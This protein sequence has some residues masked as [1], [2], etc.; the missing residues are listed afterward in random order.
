MERPD[1]VTAENAYN[2]SRGILGFTMTQTKQGIRFSSE[3]TP[4][5]SSFIDTGRTIRVYRQDDDTLLAALQLAQEKWGG[6]KLNGTE[7]YKRRCAEIAVKNGIRVTNPEL[8]GV[9]NEIERRDKEQTAP[10]PKV[11]IF[12]LARALA[13]SKLRESMVF[14]TSAMDGREYHGPLLGVVE[15]SGVYLAVQAITDNQAVTY[16]ADKSD[17]PALK[18]LEGREAIMTGEDYHLRTVEDAAI[19]MPREKNRHRGWSR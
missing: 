2:E 13:K 15:S 6:V 16:Y 4:K 14:V 5:V 10:T 9:M 1:G 8:Q 7:E 12:A 11:D 18:A 17:L 19:A 3:R